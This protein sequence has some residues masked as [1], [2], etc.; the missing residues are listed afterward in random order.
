MIYPWMGRAVDGPMPTFLQYECPHCGALVA[1]WCHTR[2]GEV[3][4]HVHKART[5]RTQ[6][7]QAGVLP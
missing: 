3:S 2:T 4:R 1:Y 5:L 7:A 6:L